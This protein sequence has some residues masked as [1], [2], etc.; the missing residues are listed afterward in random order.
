MLGT[1]RTDLLILISSAPSAVPRALP[2]IEPPQREFDSD[3][4]EEIV[5]DFVLKKRGMLF[6][7]VHY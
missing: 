5:P 4:E 2:E 3:S 6:V 1:R 7:A